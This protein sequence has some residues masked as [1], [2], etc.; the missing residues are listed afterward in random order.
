MKCPKCERVKESKLKRD[1][2][3]KQ[4][5]ESWCLDCGVRAYKYVQHIKISVL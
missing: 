3:G 4:F 5:L 1:F 2:E